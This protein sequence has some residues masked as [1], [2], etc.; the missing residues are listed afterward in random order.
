MP[1]LPEVE[2]ICW[3]LRH[4]GHGETAL[5]G[6]TVM[7]VHLPDPF[8]VVGDVVDVVPLVGG[9]ASKPFKAA[10]DIID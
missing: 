5:V 6:R 3:R 1:E 8:V 7:A 10:G 4:G 2:T 9:I